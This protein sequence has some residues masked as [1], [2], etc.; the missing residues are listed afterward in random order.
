MYNVSRKKSGI[1][2]IFIISIF[3]VFIIFPLESLDKL[4][5]D[6]L[7]ILFTTFL[8]NDI[9]LFLKNIV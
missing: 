5:F 8:C 4:S 6:K 2:D 7:Y 1:S 9:K 3:T